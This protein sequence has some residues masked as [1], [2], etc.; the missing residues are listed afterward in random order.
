MKFKVGDF[1]VIKSLK[2]M[3]ADAPHTVNLCTGRKY[4]EGI[5]ARVVGV[6][7]DSIMGCEVCSLCKANDYTWYE[8][9]LTKIV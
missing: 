5:R 4:Y 3:C 6:R 1:V 8:F 7:Y 9:T 2:D